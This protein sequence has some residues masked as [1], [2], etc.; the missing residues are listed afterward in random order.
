MLERVA[1][2]ARLHAELDLAVLWGNAIDAN[3]DDFSDVYRL[4]NQVFGPRR[5]GRIHARASHR[6][7]RASGAG[8]EAARALARG[9][10][11]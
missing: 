5:N 7:T 3:L 2:L 11:A 1:P 4:V 6:A 10:L 8:E 9:R